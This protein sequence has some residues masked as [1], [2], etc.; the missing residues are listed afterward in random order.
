M[1]Y[2]LCTTISHD[3][4]QHMDEMGTDFGKWACLANFVAGVDMA[5]EWLTEK[6][7]R[8]FVTAMERCRREDPDRKREMNLLKKTVLVLMCVGLGITAVSIKV[9]ADTQILYGLLG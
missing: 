5:L 7:D 1:A 4:D 3:V 6:L 9:A 2:E 8:K